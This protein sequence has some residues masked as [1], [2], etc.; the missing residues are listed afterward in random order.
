MED[1]LRINAKEIGVEATVD[2]LRE[3]LVQEFKLTVA[4]AEIKASEPL[5]SAGVG[6]SSL[7]GIEL[8]GLLEKR[9][10]VEFQDLEFWI[11]ESPTLHCVARYLVDNSS[12]TTS[13]P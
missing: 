1:L 7:E 12:I 10:G 11:D 2:S 13:S 9:Y 5:F 6:L 3:L 4:P 8:L